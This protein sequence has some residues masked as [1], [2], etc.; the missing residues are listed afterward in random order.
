M[1]PTTG[2]E[3]RDAGWRRW[4]HWRR[5]LTPWNVVTVA[6]ALW[7]A[8]RLLPHVAAVVGVDTGDRRAPRYDV[9]TLD[10]VRHTSESLRGKVVLVNVWATWC[11]PCRAEMPLLERMYVRH[12]DAGLVVLGLSVD[13]APL[14]VIRDFVRQR[15]VT[16]P[17]ALVG[18][19]GATPFGGVVGYP[20]SFLID[21]DGVVRHQVLG[22]LAPASLEPAVRRLLATR[23]RDRAATAAPARSE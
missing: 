21:R 4:R 2:D 7:A 10:G 16:Y 22:P 19:D 9:T 20:T 12:H 5:W 14:A 11:G 18:P 17:V 23:A 3:A 13:R 1:L 15:G 8:P 6:V